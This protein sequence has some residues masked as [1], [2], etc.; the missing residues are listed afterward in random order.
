MLSKVLFESHGYS[1]C[2]TRGGLTV[3]FR[4][5]GKVMPPTHPQFQEWLDAFNNPMDKDESLALCREFLK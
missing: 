4:D 1:V 2:L 5:R 3:Q